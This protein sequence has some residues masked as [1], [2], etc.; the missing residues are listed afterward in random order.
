[1]AEAQSRHIMTVEWCGDGFRGIFADRR[2]GCLVADEPLT[3]TQMREAL[4][5]FW[6]ILDPRSQA[7]TEAE[8]ADYC[9]F[10]PLA[11]YCATC[12]IVLKVADFDALLRRPEAS[13]A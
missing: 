5:V 13:D 2:G 1:M 8:C 7:M 3:D 12:G 10:R 6:V 4:D 9:R 11:E